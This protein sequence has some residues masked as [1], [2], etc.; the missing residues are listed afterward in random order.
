MLPSIDNVFCRQA[1]IRCPVP[2]MG[3]SGPLCLLPG[4]LRL[5]CQPSWLLPVPISGWQEKELSCATSHRPSA[6]WNCAAPC[7]KLLKVL[8]HLLLMSPSRPGGGGTG[9]GLGVGHLLSLQG[10]PGSVCSISSSKDQAGGKGR[11]PHSRS[12]TAASSRCLQPKAE[13]DGAAAGCTE[14]PA[15]SGLQASAA[16][17]LSLQ[18]C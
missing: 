11:D 5:A 8:S 14:R 17:K 13:L 3:K 4:R 1:R 7:T 6:H 12:C 10:V 9:A 16:H 2:C 18:S 15:A